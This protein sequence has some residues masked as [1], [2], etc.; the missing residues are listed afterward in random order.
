MGLL[1]AAK[2]L[3]PSIRDASRSA[4]AQACMPAELVEVLREK[5]CFTALVPAEL[6]GADLSLDSY[7]EFVQEVARADA[8]TAWCVMV[9]SAMAAA[10]AAYASNEA[11]QAV[12]AGCTPIVG[13]ETSPQ[14][15]VVQDESGV[16]VGGD[17]R[18]G[19]GCQYADWFLV[20]FLRQTTSEPVHCV[21]VL[22]REVVRLDGGWNVFGLS[23]TGS[24]NFH[25]E[26]RRVPESYIFRHNEH[27]ALRGSPRNM[28]G[29]ITLMVTGHIGV[30]LG[31]ATRALEELKAM[32]AWKH[33][34]GVRLV[35]RP[36]FHVGFARATAQLRSI[37]ALSH[38]A[39]LAAE[40]AANVP[41]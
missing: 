3:T 23:G 9:S 2:L 26:Q 37:R 29:L 16:Q 15:E 8:S 12:F 7:L 21:A 19:S 39:V 38:Q 4:E 20:G 30:A 36:D 33:T 5:G 14:A 35:D 31:L 34:D 40:V 22:P 18:F 13:G 10:V 1:E 28:L 11:A 25:V 24:I 32:I 27:D 17:L 41:A 6:G